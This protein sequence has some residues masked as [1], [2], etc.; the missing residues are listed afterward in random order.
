VRDEPAV[1]SDVGVGRYLLR[2]GGLRCRPT[3]D[4]RNNLA[5][6]RN[7][8]PS[9]IAKENTLIIQTELHSAEVNIKRTAN[10]INYTALRI[11][12]A[13]E[14]RNHLS[15]RSSVVAENVMPPAGS[16]CGSYM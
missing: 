2:Q 4:L 12:K 9:P 6:N 7:V 14:T 11:D 13:S 8:G 15:F 10:E 16:S 3:N 5:H 1:E